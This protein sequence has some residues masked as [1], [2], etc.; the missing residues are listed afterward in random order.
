MHKKTRPWINLFENIVL[1][2]MNCFPYEFVENLWVILEESLGIFGKSLRI[3]EGFLR[4][5]IL[6]WFMRDSRGIL[7]AFFR[8]TW[9]I[10][11]AFLKDPWGILN[12][13]LGVLEEL[14][15]SLSL[16]ILEQY[17]TT[18]MYDLVGFLHCL[19][20]YLCCTIPTVYCT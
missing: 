10:L 5:V 7:E 16:Y 15:Y 1:Y 3:L 9:S 2:L 11:V 19:L 12:Y 4:G 8:Y 20:T 13:S 14:F 6:E 18:F 17:S